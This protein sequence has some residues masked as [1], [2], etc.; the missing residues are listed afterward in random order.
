MLD[1]GMNVAVALL[2]AGAQLVIAADAKVA[3]GD[4]RALA[5]A[6]HARL[7]DKGRVDVDAMVAALAELQRSNP[8]FRTWRAWVP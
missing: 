4:S 2:F 6:L 3:D 7:P 8:R 5:Q 1:G